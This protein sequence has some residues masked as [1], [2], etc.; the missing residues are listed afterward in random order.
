MREPKEITEAERLVSVLTDWV[1]EILDNQVITD[2]LKRELIKET[3]HTLV[4]E[5]MIPDVPKEKP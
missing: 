4:M 3:I 1:L 2:V 5:A